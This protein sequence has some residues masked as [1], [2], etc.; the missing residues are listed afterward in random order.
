MPNMDMEGAENSYVSEIF[1]N[2]GQ[3]EQNWWESNK[4]VRRKKTTA[5][6]AHTFLPIL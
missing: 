2:I 5:N 1:K 4:T 6:I 3:I